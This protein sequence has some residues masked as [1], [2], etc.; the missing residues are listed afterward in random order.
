MQEA[1]CEQRKSIIALLD[2]QRIDEI[3][4]KTYSTIGAS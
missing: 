2:C 1:A 3:D 4:T